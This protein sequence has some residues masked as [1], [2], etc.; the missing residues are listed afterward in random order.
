MQTVYQPNLEARAI[1]FTAALYQLFWNTTHPPPV[2][3]AAGPSFEVRSNQFGFN[4]TRAS[5]RTLV[6][7]AC[8]NLANPIW[9][10]LQTNTLTG[11]PFYFS[12]ARWTNYARRFYR[13][14]SL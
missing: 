10:S 13:L 5:G 3:Q 8:T 11:D 12:D 6:V 4:V 2:I 7:E 1:G 14:R 9:L